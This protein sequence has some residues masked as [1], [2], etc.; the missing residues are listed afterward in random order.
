MNESNNRGF[1]ITNIENILT[2]FCHDSH[3]L[4]EIKIPIN[5]PEFIMIESSMDNYWRC[6]KIFL[7]KRY[8]LANLEVFK[9]GYGLISLRSI[10]IAI[11]LTQSGEGRYEIGDVK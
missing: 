2:F 5:D 10:A 1:Y 9:F 4:R 3:Y 7:G 11:L 8:E 6:S